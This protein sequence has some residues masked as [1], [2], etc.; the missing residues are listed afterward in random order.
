M[1]DSRRVFAWI[2]HY[3]EQS[4][5]GKIIKPEAEYAGLRNSKY[6]PLDAKTV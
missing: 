6:V 3:V 1:I 5:E 2:A 4:K